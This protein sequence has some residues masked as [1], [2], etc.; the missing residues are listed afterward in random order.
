MTFIYDTIAQILKSN[1]KAALCT[2]VST[3][4]STP[5]KA[6][7]K[8]IVWEDGQIAGSVGGGRLENKV[9]E[10]AIQII[11]DSKPQLFKHELLT[12]HEMCCGGKLEIYIEP[13][14]QMKKLYLFGAGHIG[15][16]VARHALNLDFEIY[17]I[18][19]REHV[20]DDWT[21][22]GFHKMN[23]NYD[24][25][26]PKLSFDG[27]TYIVIATYDHVTDREI[28]S[29]CINKPHAYLGM[30]G[31]KNK[32]EVTRKMFISADL[33]SKEELDKVDM[34]IGIPIHAE[35]ADEIGISIVAKLINEKNKQQKKS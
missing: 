1:Q 21:F 15:N 35:T 2:I 18:D 8:M 33:A 12:Q 24:D 7:A 29:Q 32:I 13:I 9:I 16:A 10:D 31:S 4:G 34:P 19:N 20:F 26:I 30:I 17:G 27:S 28:L 3:K 25:V 14:M 5:L 23:E 22:E 11:E 6:G